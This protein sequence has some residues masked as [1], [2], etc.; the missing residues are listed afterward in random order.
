MICSEEK[1][2]KQV[3]INL[4]SN[5]IKFTK[6][7]GYVKIVVEYIKRQ[8]GSKKKQQQSQIQHKRYY[9]DLSSSSGE[10]SQ[11]SDDQLDK[12]TLK[13]HKIQNIFLPDSTK[14]KIVISVIDSGVGIKR[15]DR[16]RLF[17]LFGKIANTSSMNTGGIGLGLVIS[18]QIVKCFDGNIGVKSRYGQGS[19][20]A[21]SILLDQMPRGDF[22]GT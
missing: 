11:N 8:A 9:D 17:K 12:A 3:L 2:I 6:E 15:E 16:M 19:M 7:G 14:D 18:E 20:F 5:A 10:E 4:Q 13:E 1:R 22:E 21:F